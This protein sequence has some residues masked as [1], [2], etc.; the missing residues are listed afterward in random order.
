M[1]RTINPDTSLGALPSVFEGAALLLFLLAGGPEQGSRISNSLRS[2]DEALAQSQIKPTRRVPQVRRLNLGLGVASRIHRDHS[3]ALIA[4][5]P[6]FSTILCKTLNIFIT[7]CYSFPCIPNP[8]L[9]RS[10]LRNLCALGVSALDSLLDLPLT[11]YP[12]ILLPTPTH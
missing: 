3:A 11:P 5:R 10:S 12:T 6:S 4:V 1:A 8:I 2:K 9:A 7:V